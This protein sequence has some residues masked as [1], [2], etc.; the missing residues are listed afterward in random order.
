MWGEGNRLKWECLGVAEGAEEVGWKDADFEIR[1]LGLVIVVIG[2]KLVVVLV[3]VVETVPAKA[4]EEKKVLVAVAEGRRTTKVKDGTAV[5]LEYGI[6]ESRYILDITLRTRISLVFRINVDCGSVTAWV[7]KGGRMVLCYVQ[8]SGRRKR[9]KGVGCGSGR[10][11]NYESERRDCGSLDANEDIGVVEVSSAIDDV[12]DIGESNVKSIE[13][14]SAFREFSENKESLKEVVEGGGEF[15]GRLDEINLN[16]SKELADNGVN[17]IPASLVAHESPRVRQLRERIGIGDAHGL[18]DN[19]R[20]HK[21]VQP[22][23]WG[24]M[25]DSQS[26]YSSYHL[27]G[28]KRK[29]DV[30][31]GSGRQEIYEVKD[32]TAVG[33]GYEIP[34]SR[35]ILDITL[36]TRW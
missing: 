21:F 18:M 33:L 11:E 4:E 8:G 25:S 5:G 15:D 32:E 7:A 23:V 27:E 31:C 13:V 2:K 1:S 9:K 24:W 34:E 17:L 36:M 6:P 3:G 14:L 10:Q 28:K 35:Y 16:L 22:N 29:K 26:A 20:N 12:F 30:G 19:G